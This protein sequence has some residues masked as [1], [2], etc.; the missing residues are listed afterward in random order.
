MEIRT[1]GIDLG[2]TSFH[3][4]GFDGA[5]TVVLRRRLSRPP[6][7]RFSRPC[8]RASSAWRPAAVRTTSGVRAWPRVT[9]CG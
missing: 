5:G 7:M 6:L 3:A 2:N 1:L 9:T 4:V 8:H